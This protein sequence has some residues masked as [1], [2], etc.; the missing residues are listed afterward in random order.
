MDR[1]FDQQGIIDSVRKTRRAGFDLVEFP[2]MDPTTFDSS[3]ARQALADEG[4]GVTSSLGLPVH[5][6]ISSEDDAVVAAG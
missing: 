2:L 3:T 4:L 1:S 5:A 6:D